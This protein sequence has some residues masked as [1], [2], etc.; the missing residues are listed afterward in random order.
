MD[1]VEKCELLHT[2]SDVCMAWTKITLLPSLFFYPQRDA[3]S[4]ALTDFNLLDV[5]VGEE[6]EVE[7]ACLVQVVGTN[8]VTGASPRR[9]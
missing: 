7:G 6:P 4:S 5:A 9:R 1:R 3:E 2:D 8:G